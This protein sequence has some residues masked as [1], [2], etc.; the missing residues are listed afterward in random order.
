MHRYA[1]FTSRIQHKLSCIPKK[2]TSDIE[3]Y[4]SKF[5]KNDNMSSVTYS[6]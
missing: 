5:G 3:Q 4:P 2:G 6:S 1:K